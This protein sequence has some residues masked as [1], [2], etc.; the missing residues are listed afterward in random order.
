MYFTEQIIVYLY[1]CYQ[2]LFP[3]NV[4]KFIFYMQFLQTFSF[5]IL[6]F[7]KLTYIWRMTILILLKWVSCFMSMID[8]HS[9][10]LKG[11]L[12]FTCISVSTDSIKYSRGFSRRIFTAEN[13]ELTL[14]RKF[15]FV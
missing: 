12:L 7:L 2:Y 4:V 15:N 3:K 9:T 8:I 11:K 14:L 10:L 6:K 13:K 1:L 5:E